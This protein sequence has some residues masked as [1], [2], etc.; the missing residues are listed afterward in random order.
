MAKNKIIIEDI[1]D[2]IPIS[3]STYNK[4][5]SKFNFLE[6]YHI[7]NNDNLATR[8]KR[9]YLRDIEG[10]DREEKDVIWD[11]YIGDS[12]YDLH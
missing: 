10:L 5:R 1:L 11:A 4:Y 3:K 12:L 9:S 8:E 6:L 7:F 2:L